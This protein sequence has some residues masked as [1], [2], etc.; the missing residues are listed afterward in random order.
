ME[1]ESDGNLEESKAMVVVYFIVLSFCYANNFAYDFDIRLLVI[2]KSY[3]LT[4]C[5]LVL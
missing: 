4:C 3:K 5:H 2:I 1:T